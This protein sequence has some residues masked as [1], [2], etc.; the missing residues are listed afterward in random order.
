[1]QS[2]QLEWKEFSVDLKAIDAKFKADYP[3]NY[4]G[5]QAHSIMELYFTEELTEQMN[6]DIDAYWD[7]LTAESAEATSYQSAAQLAQVTATQKTSAKAKLAALG[8]TEDE[9]K[10]LVG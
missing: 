8:L 6:T 10:A 5:N 2:K 4:A 1:M 3:N 9:I 7:D